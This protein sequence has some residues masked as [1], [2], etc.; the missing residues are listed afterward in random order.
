[1]KCWPRRILFRRLTKELK[2]LALTAAEWAR[3]KGMG[4]RA[5]AR[6]RSY[7]LDAERKMGEM[8]AEKPSLSKSNLL[9]G[10]AIAPRYEGG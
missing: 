3:R 4:E 2:T 1:M 10:N 6:C 7:A 9:R 8:L 5:I